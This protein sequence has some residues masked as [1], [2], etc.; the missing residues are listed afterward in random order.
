MK[1]RG[2]IMKKILRLEGLDC[3]NCAAK[4]EDGIKKIVGVEEATVSFMTQ[5]V[6]LIANDENMESILEQAIKVIKKVEPD[7]IIK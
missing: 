1:G 7:I 2:A 5:K 3:A 4:M 6:T